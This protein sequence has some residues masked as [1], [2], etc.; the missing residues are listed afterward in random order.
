[1][2][3]KKT[4]LKF[5]NFLKSLD[6][7]EFFGSG[8]WRLLASSLA[9]TSIL[10]MIPFLAI[11]LATLQ[12]IGGFEFLYPKVEASLLQYFKEATG[13]N[14]VSFVRASLR[15][16]N[17]GALGSTGIFLLMWATYTLLR[18]VESAFNRIWKVKSSRPLYKRIL[19][20]W[21]I[22]LIAPILLAIFAGFKS[23][24][25]TKPLSELVS[26]SLLVGFFIFWGLWMLYKVVPAAKVKTSYAFWGAV[27]SSVLITLIQKSLSWGAIKF[28]R[29]NKVYGSL[30]AVP[31]ILLWLLFVWYV[32]LLG[33]Y[34]CY[35]M[36][37]Q[38]QKS[39]DL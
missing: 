13:A 23:F 2:A 20:Y 26:Q 36:Q 35:Y 27:F 6:E 9:F 31:I 3:L 12:S 18:D 33:S 4:F 11:V 14:V 29:Y 8:E 22:F 25:L 15:R 24:E 28:Y 34:F 32:I 5:K 10:S 21:I 17:A 38:N 19:I 16:I 7:S 1:M 39:G 37:K 30:A